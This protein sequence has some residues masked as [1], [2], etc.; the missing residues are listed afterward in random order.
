M[1]VNFVGTLPDHPGARGKRIYRHRG[2]ERFQCFIVPI[3]ACYE[4]TGKV[5]RYW[6]GFDGG[7]EVWREIEGFFFDLRARSRDHH[8]GS[9][10]V[11]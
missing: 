11:E 6:K 5:R 2:E 10:A 1:L 4:L 7:E 9:S 8:E 3:D